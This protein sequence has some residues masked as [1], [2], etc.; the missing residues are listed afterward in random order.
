MSIEPG[1]FVTIDY[2]GRFE[3]GTLFGTSKWDVASTS[4][5]A[6]AQ[7]RGEDEYVPLSFT[8]GENAVIE[9]LDERLIGL[10][11]GESTTITIPPEEAYGAVDPD[12]IRE[13]DKEVFAGMV[14]EEPEV[15]LH[16]HAENGLHGDVIAIYD[17]SVEID[18]NHELA[19]RTLVIDVAIHSIA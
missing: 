18:F 7:G 19:G 11:E 6:A 2:V 5:L 1:D 4:G 10:T 13:Y 16:V 14:G 17:D 8:V 15:G 9:G 3:D 12:R